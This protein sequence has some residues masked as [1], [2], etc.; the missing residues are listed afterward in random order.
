MAGALATVYCTLVNVQDNR[1]GNN[2]LQ[3]F[4]QG[5]NRNLDC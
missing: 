4:L 2:K 1:L 3:Q 5:D